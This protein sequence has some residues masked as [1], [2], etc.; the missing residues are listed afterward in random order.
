MG[1]VL[2]DRS[3]EAVEVT[4]VYPR[5]KLM[6]ESVEVRQQLATIGQEL[7]RQLH[8]EVTLET[9]AD[10]ESRIPAYGC[11]CRSFY[12]NYKASN[13]PSNASFFKWT[14]DLHNAVNAKLGKPQVA[15]E[16]ARRQ[17]MV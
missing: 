7:W 4:V 15:L 11:S 16:D 9:L 5:R 17:W 14:V 8:S 12:I 6:S 10:W 3:T 1:I 13:P 2:T